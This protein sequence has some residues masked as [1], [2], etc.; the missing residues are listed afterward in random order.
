MR[1][2]DFFSHLEHDFALDAQPPR[3]SS[4]RTSTVDKDLL[5]VCARAK[6]SGRH[7]AVGVVTG[8]VFHVSPRAVSREWFSGLVG[9]E[10]GSGVVIPAGAVVWVES[11]SITFPDKPAGLV[12]ATLADVLTDIARRRALVTIRTAHGDAVGTIEGVGKGFCDLVAPAGMTRRFPV[13]AI[14]AIFQG[15]VTWG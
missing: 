14:V 11:D 2:I 10:H 3:E 13:S 6:A 4:Q 1:W 15:T 9:G 12:S 7:V 8:E 5:D